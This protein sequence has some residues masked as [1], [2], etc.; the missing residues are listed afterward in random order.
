[1]NAAT[2]HSE[3]LPWPYANAAALAY[4]EE[5]KLTPEPWESLRQQISD[6]PEPP[7]FALQ[8]VRVLQGFWPQYSD[9]CRAVLAK[10]VVAPLAVPDDESMLHMYCGFLLAEHRDPQCF[11]IAQQLMQL[12]GLACDALMGYEW[13]DTMEGWL[14]S[15]CAENASRREWLIERAFDVQLSNSMR[16]CAMTALV[17][18]VSGGT[19]SA[20][21]MRT[22]IFA[23]IDS[24]AT[25]LQN[26]VNHPVP[27]DGY[28][29]D[30]TFV[31]L[32][33]C[34]LD[35][36][37]LDDH[38]ATLA[39]IK[40]VY[41]AGHV[42]TEVVDWA[43]LEESGLHSY[44]APPTLLGCTVVEFGWWACFNPYK[45]QKDWIDDEGDDSEANSALLAQVR[46]LR[47]D[48][49]YLDAFEAELPFVRETP[50]VGRNEACPCGSGKK[51]KKC[52]G[53]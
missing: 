46:A 1:M 2:Y 10:A 26:G 33:I 12:S 17:R 25:C 9:A 47:T 45:R 43:D 35:D 31:G 6:V 15:F 30:R 48:P 34:L 22:L 38:A 53:A 39:R 27:H 51:F 36:F 14:A 50:K 40:L 11:D 24:V 52:C 18:F 23:L 44:R 4:V 16:L 29:G 5:H 28:M 19:L 8:A 3:T 21:R 41:E 7:A 20:S 37:D 32:L 42:D 13:P 49:G